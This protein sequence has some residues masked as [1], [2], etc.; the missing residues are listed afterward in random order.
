MDDRFLSWDQ[1][2]THHDYYNFV[3]WQTSLPHT[4]PPTAE[5]FLQEANQGYSEVEMELRDPSNLVAG[6]DYFIQYKWDAQIPPASTGP[7]LSTE[8]EWELQEC[9]FPPFPPDCDIKVDATGKF[10]KYT[11]VR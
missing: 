1:Q 8:C 6:V 4:S 11:L 3:S 10:R 7:T 9:Q 2:I 5:D